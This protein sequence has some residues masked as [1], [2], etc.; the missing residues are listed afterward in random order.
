MDGH[1]H[2]SA[3]K[4][5]PFASKQ[6]P[7]DGKTPNRLA[8]PHQPPHLAGMTKSDR[9]ILRNSKTGQ[10][11]IKSDSVQ[12]AGRN[13]KTGRWVTEKF[14]LSK[15]KSVLIEAKPGKNLRVVVAPKTIRTSRRD[16]KTA[17]LVSGV[18]NKGRFQ[19]SRPR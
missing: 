12:V 7:E 11:T 19:T 15:G 14:A 2:P 18:R 6:P 17:K 16:V 4:D 10:I 13:E 5:G 8:L 9:F 1:G 3:I